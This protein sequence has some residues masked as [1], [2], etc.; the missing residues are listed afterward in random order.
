MSTVPPP[1]RPDR[2]VARLAPPGSE[3]FDDQRLLLLELLVDP[4]A[5]GDAIADLAAALGR[6]ATAIAAAAAALARVGLAEQRDERVRA[7]EAARA[8]DALWP[9]C[10]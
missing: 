9:V 4:P 6:P 3:A 1:I 10:L 7:S 5:E 2:H 8:F